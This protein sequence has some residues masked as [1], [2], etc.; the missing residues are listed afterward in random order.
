MVQGG[1]PTG[2]G[3]GGQSIYGGAFPDEFHSRIKFSHRGIV[4]MANDGTA[5]FNMS[6]FFITVEACPWLERKHTIFGKVEGDTIYNLL[7][8]SETETDKKTDRPT[9]SPIP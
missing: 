5:N 9:G 3:K 7:K 8:I 2:T 1:D 6:Q 4:A